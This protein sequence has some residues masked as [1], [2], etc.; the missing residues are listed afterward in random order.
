MQ[1]N[2]HYVA[3]ILYPGTMQPDGHY[4][5]FLFLFSGYYSTCYLVI[6]IPVLLLKYYATLCLAYLVHYAFYLFA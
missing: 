3:F 2:G 6:R 4:V 1:P 5:A